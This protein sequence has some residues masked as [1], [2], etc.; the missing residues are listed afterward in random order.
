[1]EVENIQEKGTHGGAR[2]NAGRKPGSANL[3]TREIAN[4][5]AELGLT[6]LEV[7]VKAMIQYWEEG[8]TENA[9]KAAKDAAPYIHPR[10]SAVE[11]AGDQDNPVKMVVA[12]K[13]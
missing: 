11:V 5:C 12:W 9:V 8:D 7:I 1:M 13:S 4:K 10:L 6:P 3:K 2:P